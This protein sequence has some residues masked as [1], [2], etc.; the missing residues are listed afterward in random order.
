MDK[1]KPRSESRKRTKVL[2]VRATPEEYEQLSS[3]AYDCGYSLSHFLRQA[4]L[5][6]RVYSVVDSRAVVELGNGVR[7]MRKLGG[8]LKLWLANRG[9][10]EDLTQED[11]V[12]IWEVRKLLKETR[13]VEA[14]LVAHA[15]KLLG[16]DQKI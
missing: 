14:K 5:G 7:E 8:L 12:D 10:F 1:P 16:Y 15:E 3:L 2:R 13:I 6:K 11:A 4:G 9:V